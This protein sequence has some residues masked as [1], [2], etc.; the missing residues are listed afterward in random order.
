MQVAELTTIFKSLQKA[1][2]ETLA[3]T[4][5]TQKEF[6]DNLVAA[7]QKQAEQWQPQV[8][9]LQAQHFQ[10]YLGQLYTII[11]TNSMRKKKNLL[12]TLNIII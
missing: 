11:L 3:R 10:I 9:H 8:D 2:E 7:L 5:Q 4:Q 1:Q 12:F 6:N